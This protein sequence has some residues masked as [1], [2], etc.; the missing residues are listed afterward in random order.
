MESAP[1]R[2][3]ANNA[4]GH[5]ECE[6][7]EGLTLTGGAIHRRALRSAESRALFTLEGF[8]GAVAEGGVLGFLAGA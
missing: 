1:T 2:S 8:M 5:R 6:F 3:E 7:R 4:P